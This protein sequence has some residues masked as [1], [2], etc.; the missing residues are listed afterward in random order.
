MKIEICEQMVQS[1]LQHCKQC[2]FVQTNWMVSPL[3]GIADSEIKAVGNIMKD[4]ETKLN[5]ALEDETKQILQQSVDEELGTKSKKKVKKLDIFKK[6]K[7]GQF[8]RQ[9]EIDVAG[10][11]LDCGITERIYLVDTAFHKTG[12]GYHDAAARVIKKLVRA[13]LVS[14]I[15]FGEDVPVTVAFASPKCSAALKDNIEKI[16]ED[17]R[18]I[19]IADARYKNIDIELY[20]NEK[21]TEDI[22]APLI[23]N[24]E[25]LNNDNDLFMRAMNLAKL[26][27]EYRVA[28]ATHSAPSASTTTASATVSTRVGRGENE[29]LVMTALKD[30]IA[31]G[32]LT[33]ALV[34]ELRKPS[35]TKTNFGITKY[36]LLLK[37]SEFSYYGYERCRFYKRTLKINGENYLVCSQWYSEKIKR[38]QNWASTL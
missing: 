5:Q 21:F 9:C 22:Y 15:V 6:S 24:I 2:E 17:L 27:E 23:A 38:L 29:R 35:Y 3:R 30:V 34:D 4:I 11:K 8:I 31:N 1:W 33:P 37:E 18:N 16:V 28:P 26:A 14:L 12:L 10:C 25:E 36:P 13:L 32:K 20:F 7:A 19:L